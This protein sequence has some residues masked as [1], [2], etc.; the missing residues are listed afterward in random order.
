MKILRKALNLDIS[1]SKKLVKE[2]TKEGVVDSDIVRDLLPNH[3][4]VVK[5]TIDEEG[6]LSTS[7]YVDGLDFSRLFW[8]GEIVKIDLSL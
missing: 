5:C 6:D 2:I 8:S 4:V 3:K 7:V 1:V